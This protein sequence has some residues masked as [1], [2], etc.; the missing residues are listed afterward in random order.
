M[1]RCAAT[2]LLSL[3]AES[4]GPGAVQVFRGQLSRCEDFAG[5]GQIAM[6]IEGDKV[7]AFSEQ[8]PHTQG[9]FTVLLPN[10]FPGPSPRYP[11]D[12]IMVMSR[13]FR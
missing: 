5:G 13:E 1:A 2:G 9:S 6:N 12:P 4:N 8:Q 11:S 7:V 3:D 10:R